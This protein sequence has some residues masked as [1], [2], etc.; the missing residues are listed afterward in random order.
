MI[1]RRKRSSSGTPTAKDNSTTA[2]TASKQANQNFKTNEQTTPAQP[3]VDFPEPLKRRIVKEA[4]RS[5]AGKTSG[6]L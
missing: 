4:L 1:W 6:K 3:A 2:E 5:S